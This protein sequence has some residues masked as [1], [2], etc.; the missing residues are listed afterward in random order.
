MTLLNPRQE[1]A[2]DLARE[3]QKLD[4]VWVTNP[5][6]LDDYAKLR[7]QVLDSRKTEVLQMLADWGW[8]PAWCSNLPRITGNGWQLAS[9]YE[10]DPLPTE[11]QPVRDDR[12][13]IP[14]AEIA[15]PKKTDT[16]VEAVMRYLGWKK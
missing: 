11:R 13:T 9:V 15:R 10:I 2:R 16:E 8:S 5:M 7:F 1:K 6:P 14:R 3:M 12:Q 4:G